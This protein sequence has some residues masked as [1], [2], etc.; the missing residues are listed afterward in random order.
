MSPVRRLDSLRHDA[1]AAAKAHSG[2]V[3]R[4]ALAELGIDARMVAREVA[5]GRW[6]T[7]GRQTVAMHTGELDDVAKRWRAVWEVGTRVAAVDG[8]SALQAA[9]MTGF[10]EPTVHVSVVHRIA[11]R[12]HTDLRV[13]KIIRRVPQ[14][15]TEAGL[16]RVKPAYAAVR[17]AQWACSDRQAALL[18]VM[19]VQQRLVTGA[20]LRSAATSI[21]GR[22]RRGLVRTLVRDIADGAQSLGEL[23]FAALCRQRG[24]PEPSRQV[25]R[26]GPDGRIY[27]DV[28]WDN[29]LVVEIDGTAHQSGLSVSDDHLRANLVTM[30]GD[31]VLR[32][33][34]VGLR[35]RQ[36]EFM[37]Q[38][39][40][41]YLTR[42]THHRA[43]AAR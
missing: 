18:L 1:A 35:L 21:P 38:V 32:M 33:D 4:T 15:V 2:V 19:P 3:S 36:E 7:H 25:V 37:D 31:I 17:A 27:L 23:D 39:A 8:V 14:E 22:A 41:A 20:Q 28:R 42:S 40:L 12:S 30:D 13:H 24:L 26:E 43:G 16:P 29:G 5:A 10:E 6:R 34:L 11:L 9:G